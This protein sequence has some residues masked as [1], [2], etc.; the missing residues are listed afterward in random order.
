MASQTIS[1][2]D[3]EA[4]E[5][6]EETSGAAATTIWARFKWDDG[7]ETKDALIASSMKRCLAY[8]AINKLS[9]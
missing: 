5:P 2:T 3:D 7:D 4:V 9:S 8:F 1:V 6:A